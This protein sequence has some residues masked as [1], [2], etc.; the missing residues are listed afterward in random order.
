MIQ[1]TASSVGKSIVCAGLCRIFYQEG[2][3]VA[4][5][6]SQNMA[7]NSYVTLD[8]GEMGRAQV[9]QAE[10]A[11]LEPDVSMNPILLK[12]TGESVA[13]VIIDGKVYDN[14]SAVD[15]HDFKKQAV[16][17]VER[18]YQK[19]QES[20][21]LI[22]IE[23]AGSPAE[24]N[25]RE[26]DIVNMGM[27]ELVDAPVILVADIDRGGVFASIVGTMELLSVDERNRVKGVIINKFRGDIELLKPGI[28]MLE[29]KINIP[30][31]GVLPY[32]HLTI[33][34][35]DSVTDR[36]KKSLKAIS[37]GTTII[38]VVKLPRIS[39][40]TDFDVFSYYE[41]VALQYIE[42]VDDIDGLD[43]IIIPG[44]KNTLGDLSYLKE[45]GIA[46]EITKA[47]NMGATIIGI[48]GGYQM[49]GKS[50]ED[51]HNVDGPLTQNTGLGI[52]NM[53]TLMQKEKLTERIEGVIKTD[54]DLCE[55]LQGINISG[56]EIHMGTSI[57]KSME[58][59]IFTET[60]NGTGGYCADNI[61]GTYIHG[62]FDNVQFTTG[63]LN[64]IR[65]KK[66]LASVKEI[67]DFKQIKEDSFDSLAALMKEHIDM[68]K[69]KEIIYDSRNNIN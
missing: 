5:F 59:Q 19:L 49:L 60:K 33:E 31:L 11:C 35:E 29:E 42:T 56:Y 38:G 22:V 62:V 54:N 44:S 67:K 30:V 13:Q 12:P 7:L 48:C 6:K 66:G 65:K 53:D 52:I 63:L 32:T 18:A 40:F 68:D 24:I 10:A 8:G 17:F 39:N 57:L 26:N 25:L 9:V 16:P 69:I 27:A 47:Y 23:G 28:D 21:D 34:D 64:N 51:T 2:I 15:Y 50:I 58:G 46:E 55:N 14:M 45:S 37:K 36:F 20:F 41:D 1:G 3:K 4:P 61:L 43:I